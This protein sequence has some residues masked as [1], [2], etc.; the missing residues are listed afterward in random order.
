MMSEQHWNMDNRNVTKPG[1]GKSYESGLKVDV[2]VVAAAVVVVAAVVVAAV[3]D[4]D[5]VGLDGGRRCP[6]VG[7]RGSR[8]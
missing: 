6:E 5:A 8:L 1:R 2:V 7:G 3:V 4:V